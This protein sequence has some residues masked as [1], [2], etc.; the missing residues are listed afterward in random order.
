MRPLQQPTPPFW[1]MRNPE[2]AARGGMNCVVVGS[3]DTL[4]AN[5]VRPMPDLALA[6]SPRGQY[7]SSA[8]L[9]YEQFTL[10]NYTIGR[11]YDPGAVQ[12]DSGVGASVELRWGKLMPRGPEGL[13]FQPYGFL[14]A[15]WVWTND[16]GVTPSRR[17]VS[18]G[19][20]ARIRWGDHGDLNLAVAVPLEHLPGRSALPPARVLLTFSTRFV[21][22][23]SQ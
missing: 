22:W 13:A 15:G 12:G 8:L 3:I 9:S 2:T 1:Y 7:T 21:P 4:E 16:N 19:A 18:A 17:L 14:D 20:G 11:G 23:T 5:V 10:G 6:I